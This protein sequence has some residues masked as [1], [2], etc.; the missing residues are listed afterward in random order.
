MI[1][2]LN[3]NNIII[4]D[5]QHYLD[6]KC[7]YLLELFY[8]G[9]SL[10]EIKSKLHISQKQILLQFIFLG[11][12]LMRYE[13][14]CNVTPKNI[15]LEYLRGFN[16]CKKIIL[17]QRKKMNKRFYPLPGVYDEPNKQARSKKTSR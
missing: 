7:Y 14:D 16:E 10:R 8:K 15:S 9:Y 11:K 13:L 3:K 12:Q 2:L 1:N 17:A 4:K 6:R 5:L